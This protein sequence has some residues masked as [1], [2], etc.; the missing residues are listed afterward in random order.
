M[1]FFINTNIS[2]LNSHSEGSKINRQVADSLEKLSSGERINKAADDSS[3]LMIADGLRNQA[4]SLGQA[5]RNVN[6]AIGI[7]Q[8]AD[9]AM[10]EQISIADVIKVKATQSAQDGQTE[11]TRKALQADITRLLEELDNIAYTTSFNGQNLLA[12]AFNNKEFQIGAYSNETVKTSIPATYSNKIGETRFE[13]GAG[14]SASGI[15]NLSFPSVDGLH[16]ISLESVIISTSVGTGIAELANNVNKNSDALGGI[17][18]SWSLLMTADVAIVGG[19]QISNLTINGTLIGDIPDI[20]ANDRDGKLINAINDNKL[21]TGVEAYT[22]NRGNLN[23][24][25]LDGR[26]ISISGT[27]LDTIGGFSSNSMEYYGRLSLSRAGSK[28]IIVDTTSGTLG[29]GFSAGAVVAEGVMNLS[30]LRGAMG[31]NIASAFGGFENSSV[32]NY[33]NDFGVGITTLRG[34]MA[35]MELADNAQAFLDSIRA[36]LGSVQNQLVSTVNNI[37][38]TQVNAKS[39]ESHI[40]D[41]DFAKEV[42]NFERGSLL[43]QSGSFAMSQSNQVSQ[44]VMKLL[45]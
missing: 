25:S 17:K 2:S 18:A 11:S 40:R 19:G 14:I 6:D 39:S 29:A 23:L 16:D 21:E 31:A 12:G 4:N 8:I 37:S 7:V 20:Q 15:V 10:D 28:D 33:G 26:G 43:S 30:G 42:A 35:V 45:Q 41:L 38:T 3:G 24:R 36:D 27:N 5:V 32:E 44:N 13:T 22:D 9:K 34:A 1:S